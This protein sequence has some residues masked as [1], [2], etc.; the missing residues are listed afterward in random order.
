MKKQL[1][2]LF[3]GAIFFLPLSVL[4]QTYEPVPY[5]TSFENVAHSS[6]PSGWMNFATGSSSA[7]TFPCAYQHSPNARTG[8]MYFELESSSGQ[9]EISATCEF[10]NLSSLM[11]D[12]Y[13][14]TTSSSKPTTFEIGV[15]EDS[16][17]VPVDTIDLTTAS[18][19]GAS[20]YHRYRVFFNEYYGWGTRIAFRAQKSGSY[21]VMIDDLTIAVAPSCISMPSNPRAIPSAYGVTL[22][23]NPASSSMAYGVFLDGT[24]YLSYDTTYTVTGLAPNTVYNGY[25]YNIC[26]AGD[27]SETV[28]FSFRTSCAPM[29]V[30]PYIQDFESEST[31]G[32]TNTNFANCWYRLNNGTS[33][34][35]YPYISSSSSYNHTPGG[36]KGLYWYNAT[37]YTTYGDYQCIVLPPVD[38]DYYAINTLQL[39]FWAKPSSTSYNPTFYVGVM[40]DPTDINS[41]QAV[42]TIIMGGTTDWGEHTSYLTSFDGYG[43]YVG[44]MALRPSSSWYVYMDDIKL[45]QAPDCPPVTNIHV[46]GLDSNMLSIAWTENGAASSWTVEYGVHGFTAGSGTSTVVYSMP[47]VING[48]TPNTE[49]DIYVT[50]TCDGDIVTAAMATLRT[51]N[52]YVNLPLSCGFE[53]TVQNRIWLLANGTLTNK[54]YIGSAANN[55]GANSL[56]V[57]NDGT[58]LNYTNNSSTMV[59]AYCDVMIPT[60]GNYAYSFDWQ[61]NGESNY[62]FIRAALVP[63]SI[64]LVP[65][66]AMPSGM[67]TSALPAGWIAL[68]GGSKLNLQ[69]NWQ[70]RSSD[71]NITTAG[72][73][74]LVFAW[75][76]DASGGTA[77]AAAIDNVQFI[78]LSCDKPTNLSAYNLTQTAADVSWHEAGMAAEWEYQLGSNPSVI[79]YD[80]TCSLTGLTANTVYNFRVR[81]IC[82]PGDTS[83]WSTTTFRT[84]CG[85]ISLPYTETFEGYPAGSSTT[86]S[87]FIPC[88]SHLNNGTSYGGYPYLSNSSTYNHTPG[89]TAGLYWYNATTTGTY[90]D[91]QCIVLPPVDST[92]DASTLMLNFWSRSSSTSYHPEFIVGVMTNPADITSFVAVDTVYVNGTDWQLFEVPLSNYT[93]TGNLVAIRANRP[94]SSWYAYLDDVTLGY[95]PTCYHLES[96]ELDPAATQ[97]STYLALTWDNA[98]VLSYEVEYGT[99]G[100]TL[101]TGTSLTTNNNS[102]TITGLASSTVYDVYV[103]KICSVGD[104]SEW[105][106]ASFATAMCDNATITSLGSE[107]STGTSYF[108]PVNNYYK[109]T[110]SETI[111]DSAELGT[112]QMLSAISYF[113]NYATPS[114]SKTNCSIYLQHTRLSSF[115]SAS[116]M[117]ALDSTAVLVYT[118]SLNCVQGWNTFGFDTNFYYNGIDNLLVIV[119][120]NSNAYNG[121]TYLFKTETCSGNKT[122]YYYSDSNNPDAANP[123][124]FSGSMQVASSRVVMQLISCGGQMCVAP[125][126]TSVATT[127]H[128]ATV[129]WA[130]GSNSYEIAVKANSTASW[131][132]ETVVS[133]RTYTFAGLAPATSYTFRI[134][135]DCNADS[136]GYS[137]WTYGTFTT[138]SLPC[139][140]P[141]NLTASNVAHN[142]A[143]LSWTV[144]GN[145]TNW[146]LHVWSTGISD[147]TLP[148]SANPTIV[149]GLLS[150]VTYNASVRPICG[151]DLLEGDWSD[152]IQFTTPTCPNVTGLTVGNV[153]FTTVSLSWDADPAAQ[154]YIVEYGMTGFSQGAGIV[155][156]ANTNSCT[157]T[158]LTDGTSYDFYVR[159][160]CGIDWVSENWT[161]VSASTIEMPEDMFTV[162]LNVNDPTMGVV[163][164]AGTYPNGTT[165][166]ILATPFNGY[167][168]VNWSDGSTEASRSILVDQ[169]I[170]LTANFAVQQTQGIDQAGNTHFAIYPNP[171]TSSTTISV[172]GMNGVVRINVVDM[173][174]RT[175]A[176]ET[177]EC[178][179]DCQKTMSV[180]NLSQ[181]TYFVSITNDNVTMV[182]KLIV[183]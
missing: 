83:L 156:N 157:I 82:G 77:P 98:S 146:E 22:E 8:S 124:S 50:P 170:T 159:A 48:L 166:T 139:V 51:A 14:A 89:G 79:C 26:P 114:T 68:D 7:A 92:V 143:T 95:I 85:F 15:M 105:I 41:F 152:T 3:L 31:G 122:A 119:D 121:S 81:A 4:A 113:Y 23:W 176:S 178:A 6:L 132:T 164:G 131:P 161:H 2:K 86:G 24:H 20:S 183:K 96:I 97:G 30:L 72:V 123:S 66:T 111:V 154:S 45:E 142:Q 181:G 61:C 34:F 100:F 75:R 180:D 88:W 109:Y 153:T 57:S 133:G 60:A 147:Q 43:Q 103:R 136:L 127:Y 120:D 67:S 70:T 44:I 33:Y 165:I 53:D 160:S 80:T 169:D 38:T 102:L 47:F 49:Y 19:W 91:Y 11:L 151:I 59:Y 93:G 107:S 110:L 108:F 10:D 56:F 117:V 173:S 35:G 40:T 129:T 94:A 42:D 52:V 125:A 27:T 9:T 76:C 171:A 179:A 78:A 174:G 167:Q 101:G 116:D 28:P 54:W 46:E 25:I 148:T 37:T 69:S 39:S 65:G 62:D 149:N 138:D 64:D 21:T 162:T 29:T 128:D 141:T 163:G 182:K 145:E 71:L 63:V 74:H 115:G 112:P 118:G 158:D 134:R 5:T 140:T 18:G 106:M 32:S 177:F 144:R 36:N 12:F 150:G 90:G 55:G 168:F 13:A 172:A 137:D 17:F 1:R 104:T 135:Q 84:P 87:D 99:Q 155:V 73:Y 175:V 16:V 58:T 130:G 126:V